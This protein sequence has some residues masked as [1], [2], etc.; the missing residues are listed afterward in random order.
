MSMNRIISAVFF[1]L[2]LIVLH[3]SG[4][5]GGTSIGEE[6]ENVPGLCFLHM[7][8]DEGLDI[9]LIPEQANSLFPLWLCD[10]L[11]SHGDFGVSLLGI[12]LTD[13]TPQL[14][15]LSRSLG[16]GEMLQLSE[17][18]FG[19]NSEEIQNRFDLFD[20][21]G[22][23]IGSITSRDGWV[24]LITGS[25]SDRA[26]E[27]WLELER[28]ESLASDTDLF[29][30]SESEADLTVLIS[31]NSISFLSVIPTGMLSRSQ[32]RML[33]QVKELIRTIDPIA[34]SLSADVSDDDPQII[35]LEADVVRSG[36]NITS[37]SL[38]FSDTE[39]TPDD[40]ITWGRS[41][42]GDL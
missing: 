17:E 7:H 24:C 8:I 39:I 14:L 35:R 33:N 20:D 42:L 18:G 28:E 9:S 32:I 10:S 29:S 30:I 11:Q 19:C 31:H 26:A 40:L 21:R 38:T 3:G 16:T 37:M 13:F 23:M 6:L 41:L 27:R 15:F 22:S 36:G 12:N 5:G 4:C 1:V 2:L 34:L 25:G